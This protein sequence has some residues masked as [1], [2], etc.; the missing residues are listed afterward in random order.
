[1]EKTDTN[2]WIPA[3]DAWKQFAKSHPEFGVKPTDHSW[4][5]FQR[6]YAHKLVDGL[7][8]VR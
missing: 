4:I 6:T 3:S 5:Y 8:P 2:G 1:M 7:L